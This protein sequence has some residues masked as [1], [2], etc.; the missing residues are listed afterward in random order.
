MERISNWLIRYTSGKKVIFL[1]TIFL[2]YIFFLLPHLADIMSHVSQN[3]GSPDTHLFYTSSE[4]YTLISQFSEEG[5]R[6]YIQTRFSY[7]LFWPIVYVSFLSLAISFSHK[8][9]LSCNVILKSYRVYFNLLPFVAGFFD[10]FENVTISLNM[11]FYP[12]HLWGIASISG[13]C[14]LFKWLFVGLA[15]AVFFRESIGSVLIWNKLHR[16]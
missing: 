4:L 15:F 7:D 9:L 8:Y 5:R 3:Q 12:E 16:R 13:Y 6:E 2:I 10:F 14:T 11:Y 1:G